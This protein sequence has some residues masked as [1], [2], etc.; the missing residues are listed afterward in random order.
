M[1]IEDYAMDSKAKKTTIAQTKLYGTFFIDK[2]EMAILVDELQE[3]VPCPERL[4]K[5]PLTPE[6]MLGIFYFQGMIIPVVDLKL[7]LNFS[8]RPLNVH[9]HI[10]VIDHGGIKIGLVFDAIG[11]IMRI[12]DSEVC[13]FEFNSDL[14][15]R[16][17][18]GMIKIESSN[19]LIQLIDSKV[20]L[21]VQNMPHVLKNQSRTAVAIKE[22][23]SDRRKFISFISNDVLMGVH[24]DC[25]YEIL[26]PPQI[27]SSALKSALCLGLIFLREKVIPIVDF[28][29]LVQDIHS[30]IEDMEEPLLEKRIIILRIKE[31]LLGFLVDQIGGIYSYDET[32]LLPIPMFSSGRSEMFEGC[33]DLAEQGAVLMINHEKILFE[34]DLYALTRGHH[35]L[36]R[37]KEETQAQMK[38]IINFTYISFYLDQAYAFSITEVKEIIECPD[39][40][41]QIP[42]ASPHTKGVINLR[43]QLIPIIDSRLFFNLTTAEGFAKKIMIFQNQDLIFGLLVDKIGTIINV[44][45]QEKSIM[46]NIGNLD[47]STSFSGMIAESIEYINSMGKKETVIVLNLAKIIENLES[48][49]GGIAG[50]A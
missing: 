28:K 22:K 7:L 8:P 11:E 37:L 25:I 34:E 39:E 16:V 21:S 29:Y 6:F 46:L 24:I 5:V 36:Y 48:V 13:H 27:Q 20:L 19:R 9:D 30:L 14:S 23:W 10:A 49:L 43:G 31:E 4:I 26:N 3:V 17:I 15:H 1:Q 2:T 47:L 40:L 35:D 42:G 33:L 12:K 18:T 32:K 44:T 50:V 45:S 41:M 38:E